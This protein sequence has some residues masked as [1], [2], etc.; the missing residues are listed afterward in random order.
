VLS[1]RA[2][3]RAGECNYTLVETSLPARNIAPIL[4]SPL[5]AVQSLMGRILIEE[6][7]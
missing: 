6:G 7:S 5:S 1:R 2:R 4:I 3:E